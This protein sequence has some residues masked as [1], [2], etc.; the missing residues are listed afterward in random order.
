MQSGLDPQDRQARAREAAARAAVERVTPDLALGLGSGRAVWKVIELLGARAPRRAVAAS[1][2]TEERL[3]AAGIEPLALDDA[4][5]I[6]LVID[7]ADEVDPALGLIKGGGGA[8]LREKL[9]VR[10]AD[11]FV[12]VAETEKKVSRLGETR[13][14]PVEIVRF[15]WTR[16]RDRLL[17]LVPRAELRRSGDGEPFVTDNGNW[18]LDCEIPPAGDIGALAAAIKAEVG[19]VEHG[20]FLGLADEALLGTPDGDVERIAA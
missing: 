5:R 17:E 18:I 4:G 20:L 1:S 10:A 2:L 13:G 7:G 11:R 16:T 6:D 15:G 8:H 12:V 9:L 19:V 14:V 3:R